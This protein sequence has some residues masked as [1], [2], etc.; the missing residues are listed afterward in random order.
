MVKKNI[1]I[2]S[3]ILLI[4]FIGLLLLYLKRNVIY[5]ETDPIYAVPVTAGFIFQISNPSETRVTW[6]ENTSYAHEL[7]HFELFKTLKAVNDYIDSSSV[8]K[9]PTTKAF[10][11][12]TCIVSLHPGKSGQ[13]DWH[14]AIPLKN[15]KEERELLKIIESATPGNDPLKAGNTEIFALKGSV[16]P[17]EAFAASYNGVFMLSNQSRLIEAST[18]QLSEEI[19]VLDDTAFRS[20]HKTSLT[21][22]DFSVY[23]NFKAAHEIAV[24]LLN[25]KQWSEDFIAG[26]GSWS[27]L[28][29]EIHG[30]AISLNGFM[31][32]NQE[33]LFA[34][35]FRGI[36]AKKPEIPQI[37]PADT[38]FLINY[39][40][41]NT[42]RFR[43]NLL[44]YIE[45]GEKTDDFKQASDQFQTTHGQRFEDLF[46]SFLD[47]EGAF[48]YAQPG[49]SDSEG[50]HYLVFNTTGQ[51]KTLEIISLINKDKPVEL[52]RW[53][54]LD[55]QTRFPVY[56]GIQTPMMSELWG[57]LFPRVPSACFSFYRN[58]LIFA[59]SPE[60]LKTIFYSTVLNK[61]LANHPYY[62]SFTENFSFN[63]NL[64]IFAEIPYLFPMAQKILKPEVFHPTH[65]QTNALSRFYGLG[66]QLSSAQKMVYTS[67]YAN[68][69]PQ[70]D[71]EPRT[72]WQSRLDSTIIGKPALVDNHNTG[73]KE[74]LV[75]DKHNNLY[76]INNMGRV[77]WKRPLEGP[78]LSE[79]YQIDFYKNN[80]LQ[81][82]FNTKERLYLIDR[83]GNH[84]A[85][86][87]ISLPAHATNG[88]TVYDYDNNKEYRIFLALSDNRVYLF[89][90]DGNRNPGWSLPNTEGTVSTPV[91][92]VTTGGRDYIVFSD[93]YRNYLL[94]RR[95][96]TR[97]VPARSFIRNPQSLFYLETQNG[98]SQLVTTTTTGTLARIS[99]PSGQCSFQELF[100]CPETHYF[101]L[102]NTG[103]DNRY[104]YVT[105]NR[106]VAFNSAAQKKM[107][108]S[109]DRSIRTHA[110]LYQFTANDIKLGVVEEDGGQ[111][112]LI[113]DDGSSYRG[114]PLKGNSRFSIGFLKSSAYR[115]N[116]I[117]GG[118][119]NF[120]NNY[121]I[122]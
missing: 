5:E 11:S 71:R 57:P 118:D 1:T 21:S 33:A 23:I 89:D 92:F 10:L 37:I 76:L 64:F 58:Y 62:S 13:H 108:V 30:D 49:T 109:F 60:A 107:E 18:K 44:G 31:I 7:D 95:G 50:N 104:L 72:I 42:N 24:P 93:Q 84:V 55:E 36:P 103:L 28:D 86:Y 46:F 70:R 38:R 111:V 88:L 77:L 9:H 63:E 79:F 122:E 25:D 110:D 56:A 26:I 102:I 85:K 82:L 3:I 68:Y 4:A 61:S 67:I 2:I 53:I 100:E 17:A 74:I 12:R 98:T 78:V 6:F 20:I 87:P 47:G 52:T 66:I 121:R 114:F 91:Q 90:K 16:I 81:Y 48:I 29:V 27:E 59:D 8:F 32:S 105:K 51:A 117:V 106:V 54:D 112:H 116:L 39:S 120:L 15:H 40:F 83:N 96:Q 43:Q 97:V 115:F 99:L 35:L 69:T 34:V 113:N 119:H 45:A 41:S 101:T 94:D 19:S 22:K 14:V 80:K 73:E 65:D 75:Q